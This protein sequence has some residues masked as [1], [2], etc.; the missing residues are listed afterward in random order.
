VPRL[1]WY[2]LIHQLPPKPLYL[3]AKVRQRLTRIGALALKNSV[4]V[5]PR[6]DDALEDLQWIAQE[7]VAGG[8]EAFICEV[9]FVHGIDA[10]T[11][12]GRFNEERNADYRRLIA[13]VREMLRKT[14]GKDAATR[15]A[16]VLARVKKRLEEIQALDSFDAEKGKEAD[17][18]VRSLEARLR[19]REKARPSPRRDPRLSGLRGRVWVTRPGVKV[20]RIASAWL[21]RRFVDPRARFRFAD[22][23]SDARRRGEVRFD[24]VGGDYTHEE[25]RC[26]FETLLGRLGLSDPALVQ[27]GEVVHD[28]D[29]KDGKYGRPETEGLRQILEGLYRSQPDDEE[30]LRQGFSLFDALYES[31]RGPVKARRER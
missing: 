4:Y 26:T 2:L 8:G 9:D 19:K 7:A 20:D 30:R 17:A 16:G 10:E 21:V 13:E 6:R 14:T 3:R 1:S 5:L 23:A 12:V 15:L 11:L 27:V 24:M 22:P 28:I 25:D 31:F 18:M 29:L